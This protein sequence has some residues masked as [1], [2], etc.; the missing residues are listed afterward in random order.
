MSLSRDEGG[1]P[2]REVVQREDVILA[3]CE[4][5]IGKHHQTGDGAWCK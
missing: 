2:P 1:L 3:D 5:L 4:R